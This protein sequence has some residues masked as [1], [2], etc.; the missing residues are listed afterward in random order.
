[1][2]LHLRQNVNLYI[3]N[4]DWPARA[5]IRLRV[6]LRTHAYTFLH[7]RVKR[8]KCT[9]VVN[10]VSVRANC[11]HDFVV[12]LLLAFASFI[13]SAC[14][15]D[16]SQ[17]RLQLSGFGRGVDVSMVHLRRRGFRSLLARSQPNLYTH[18]IWLSNYIPPH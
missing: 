4:Y 14:A 15:Q 17:A 9:I 8:S 11:V 6:R 7:T 3:V 1:M 2:Y 12:R 5:C 10:R 16:H 18:Q 13:R